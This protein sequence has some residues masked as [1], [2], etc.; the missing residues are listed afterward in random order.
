[1]KKHLAV[2][3]AILM[4]ITC[5]QCM[6]QPK[7]TQSPHK[8]IRALSLFIQSPR[9]NGPSNPNFSDFIVS[10][11]TS[12]VDSQTAGSATNIPDF[13]FPASTSAS[14]TQIVTATEATPSPAPSPTLSTHS[15]D[16]NQA[17]QTS[18]IKPPPCS[19]ITHGRPEATGANVPPLDLTQ[20]MTTHIVEVS[21]DAK[22]D[23][24]LDL[25]RLGV[26]APPG[27]YHA[28]MANYEKK[29]AQN[30]KQRYCRLVYGLSSALDAKSE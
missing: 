2:A 28:I 23:K 27:T 18:I 9:K 21:T 8:H 22:L 5:L 3:I 15:E 19:P 4:N 10:E 25:V 26:K 11:S 14:S 24:L 29:K 1:M 12:S 30:L 7:T 16:G 13:V 20:I 17:Q 6:Q